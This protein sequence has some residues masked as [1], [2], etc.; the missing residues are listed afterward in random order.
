MCEGEE[1]HTLSWEEETTREKREEHKK[2]KTERDL[3]REQQSPGDEHIT[4]KH[5]TRSKEL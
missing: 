1:H 2:Q 5:G 4:E 3:D